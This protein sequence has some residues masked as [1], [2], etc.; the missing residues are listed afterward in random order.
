MNEEMLDSVICP[1]CSQNLTKNGSIFICN[2]CSKQFPI[3]ENI[4][5]L[6]PDIENHSKSIEK[7]MNEERKNWYTDDQIHAYDEGPYKVHLLKRI[8]FVKK[9]NP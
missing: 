1:N 2:S 9:G 4:A 7:L 3:K 8:E 5:I 6:I